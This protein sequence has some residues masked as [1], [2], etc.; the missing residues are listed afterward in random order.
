MHKDVYTTDVYT[1]DVY[2]TDV[3]TTDA[4]PV[5]TNQMKHKE[6]EWNRMQQKHV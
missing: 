2:T 4:Q 5:H 1:T 6:A 3:Y